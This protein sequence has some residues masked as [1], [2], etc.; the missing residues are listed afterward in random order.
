[1]ITWI[2]NGE[3]KTDEPEPPLKRK[4]LR[5]VLI[6]IATIFFPMWWRYR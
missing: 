6:I 3:V 5:F 2:E 4:V 1:M